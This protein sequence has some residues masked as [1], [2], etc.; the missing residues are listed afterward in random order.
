MNIPCTENA[1]PHMRGDLL[2]YSFPLLDAYSDRII[3]GFSTRLGGVSEGCFASLNLGLGRGDDPEKVE[4]NYRLLGEAV[5]FEAERT[6]ISSQT[7]GVALRE[8][9]RADE[10]K[11]LFK[12][13]DYHDIDGLFTRE[14]GP[15]LVTTYADCTPLLFYAPDRHL[16][17]T[18]HAG[19][20]GTAQK[21][22]AVTVQRLADEGC[23]PQQLR[24]VIGPSA[25]P[26]RYEVGSECAEAFAAIRDEAGAVAE[27]LAD[28][29]GKF[30]LN[31]WRANRAVLLEVGVQPQ[32]IATAGLCTISH[33]EIFYSHRICGNQ[34]GSLAAFIAL[35]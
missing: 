5:G 19:W 4:E 10:G 9:R 24:V 1:T 14:A 34:R 23:D 26:L 6:V 17:A 22:A 12:E 29:E 2:W 11:G 13:R 15:V 28:K 3:H 18:S 27:P 16:A 21:M 25:G 8:V 35:R 20:R 32:H 31:M 33:P 7:H 30:L